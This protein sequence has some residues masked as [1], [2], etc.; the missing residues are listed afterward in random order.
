MTDSF[1]QNASYLFTSESVTEGH[2]DKICDQVS[3][4]ILDNILAHDREARV[5]CGGAVTLGIVI[6]LG[7]I[8]TD[9]YVEIPKVVRNVLE[10]I[11]YTNP[12]YGFDY[13]SLGTLVSIKQQS[14]NISA[15]VSQAME[16]RTAKKIEDELEKTGAG[17]QGMMCSFLAR[18]SRWHSL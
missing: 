13:Q 17:D 16:V 9:C 12:E 18:A 4:A 7:E 2:P 1:T 14:A 10:S 8:T 6:V 11:G 15:G 3:D 5:A